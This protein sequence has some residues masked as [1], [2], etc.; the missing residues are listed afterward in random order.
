VFGVFFLFVAGWAAYGIYY[1]LRTSKRN[2]RYLAAAKDE[3]PLQL[4]HLTGGLRR[5]AQDTRLLRVSLEAPIRDI[6]DFRTGDFHQSA[7]EDLDGFD[8]ML[9]DVS[10]QLGDWVRTVERLPEQDRDRLGDMGL[11]VGP[12]QRAIEIEGGAFE[13]RFVLRP[14]HP[15]M[16]QRLRSIV[17]ELRRFEDSLQVAPRL[18]R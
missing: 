3:Q 2:E 6:A 16:D 5:L 8:N 1:V 4:E 7:A 9:L 13:R 15:P 18:Y 11:S 14:G 12:I 10:R 17:A